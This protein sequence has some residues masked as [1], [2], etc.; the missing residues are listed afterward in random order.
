MR[1]NIM[2]LKY[3]IKDVLKAIDRKERIEI[4]YRG[5]P[6]GVITPVQEHCRKSVMDHPFF[7]SMKADKRSVL[8]MM[9]ELRSSSKI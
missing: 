7:G 1:A 9:D 2:D 3:R 5:K 6:R 8:K 4:I